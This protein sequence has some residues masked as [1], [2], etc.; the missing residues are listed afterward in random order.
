MKIFIKIAVALAAIAGVVYVAAT[1][2]DKI[3]AWAKKML[4]ACKCCCSS[5]CDCDCDCDCDCAEDV[6]IEEAVEA[7]E[8]TDVIAAET[9][10][11]G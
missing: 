7:A 8:E 5:E 4:G 3:V 2:G 6:T 11:E 1:Y 9:D 10:F